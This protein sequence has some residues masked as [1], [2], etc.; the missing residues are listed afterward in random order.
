MRRLLEA[1]GV[2]VT[3]YYLPILEVNLYGLVGVSISA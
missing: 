3:D 1:M 2:G